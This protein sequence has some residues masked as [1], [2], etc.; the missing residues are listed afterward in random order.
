MAEILRN[1]VANFRG[2][3]RKCAKKA[4]VFAPYVRA[5]CEAHR[6]PLELIFCVILKDQFAND[7]PKNHA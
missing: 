5:Y 4:C 1:S 3:T 7:F 2:G 6:Y